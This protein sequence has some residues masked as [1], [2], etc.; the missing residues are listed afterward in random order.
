[1]ATV[2]KQIDCKQISLIGE[3]LLPYKVSQRL[4]DNIKGRRQMIQVNRD[5]P[6][7]FSHVEH[8]RL[9]Y[10][11]NAVH[12]YASLYPSEKEIMAVEHSTVFI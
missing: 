7:S 1:M 8:A 4:A 9:T 11:I 6:T 5:P 3:R 2:T 10:R 12:E